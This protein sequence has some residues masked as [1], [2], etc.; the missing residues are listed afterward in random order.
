MK[1]LSLT[2]VIFCKDFKEEYWNAHIMLKKAVG[3]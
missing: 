2:K 3:N 1:M